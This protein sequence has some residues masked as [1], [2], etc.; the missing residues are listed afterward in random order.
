VNEADNTADAAT[1]RHSSVARVSA[2]VALIAGTFV[3]GHLVNARLNPLVELSGWVHRAG[4]A[5]PLLFVILFLA[6]NTVG[7]PLPVLGAAAGAVFGP[8]AGATTS[9]VAMTITA[10]VQF[11][12]ARYVVGDRVRQRLGR[13]LVRASNLL[14]RRGAM[15]VAGARLV[16][17]PFS[18]FNMLAGLTVLT[19]RDFTIGTI[20]GCAPKA[21][22]WSGIGALLS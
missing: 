11:L 4:S 10:C 12:L 15:A 22:A 9:L 16:P 21:L 3:A 1:H 6:L 8:V 18:E 14:E 17:G 19:L 20:V 2:L 13:S 7:V 5:G